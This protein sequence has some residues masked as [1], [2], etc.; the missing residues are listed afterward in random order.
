MI[1]PQTT[2]LRCSGRNRPIR[3]PNVGPLASRTR[4]GASTVAGVAEAAATAEAVAGSLL[5]APEFCATAGASAPDEVTTEAEGAAA[6]TLV[7]TVGE[8]EGAEMAGRS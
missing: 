1:S 4:D 6:A 8:R 5:E 2:A 3:S 7:S